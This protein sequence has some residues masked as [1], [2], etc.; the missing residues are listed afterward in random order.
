VPHASNGA[1][2]QC[3]PRVSAR[4]VASLP[5][6]AGPVKSSAWASRRRSQARRKKPDR[7]RLTANV[8][9]PQQARRDGH[10]VTP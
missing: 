7:A 1:T 6:P 2:S 5:T 10:G 8:G 3:R 9:E 4:A